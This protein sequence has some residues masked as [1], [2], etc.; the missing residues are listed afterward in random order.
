[1]GKICSRIEEEIYAEEG[2]NI[3]A[4][5]HRRTADDCEMTKKE[6]LLGSRAEAEEVEGLDANG[7]RIGGH[8]RRKS[9]YEDNTIRKSLNKPKN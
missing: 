5:E 6:E 2:S 9:H 8:I 4:P 7:N 3:P 1:M